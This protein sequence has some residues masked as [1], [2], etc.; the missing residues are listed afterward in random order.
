ME[1]ADRNLPP[2]ARDHHRGG[3]ATVALTHF[4]GSPLSFISSSVQ[5]RRGA[6]TGG[7]QPPDYA[8]TEVVTCGNARGPVGEG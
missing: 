7:C 3:Q 2:P 8:R 5:E 4:V 1:E 6:F